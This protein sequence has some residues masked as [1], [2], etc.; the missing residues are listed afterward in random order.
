MDSFAVLAQVTSFSGT[1]GIAYDHDN[2]RI[3]VATRDGVGRVLVLDGST[4]GIL[5]TVVR[6]DQPHSVAY[7]P[8]NDRVYV[9]NY[10]CD[11]VDVYVASTMYH[12][13]EVGHVS[14]PSHL[15]VDPVVNKVYVANHTMNGGVTRI[16]GTLRDARRIGLPLA[17]PYGV[18]V[19]VARH[20]VYVTAV[21]EGR[22]A[23]V[24]ST[25]DA[26][27][28]GWDVR[29]GDGRTPWLRPAAVNPNAGVNGH[30]FLVTTDPDTLAS[31]F[32]LVPGAYPL[33]ATPVPLNIPGYPQEG[34]AFDPVASRVWVTSVNGG[35]VTVIQDGETLC[36]RPF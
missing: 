30:L 8:G 35:V 7:N 13:W 19:D 34:I 14:K 6:G 11:T 10:G 1:H 22:V 24:D 29:R 36:S 2:D 20:L 16:D 21:A 23:F 26:L 31:Q 25:N 27:L 33:P 18:A 9:T 5:S 28:A 12:E 32:L 4:Y 17:D 3:W 15:G